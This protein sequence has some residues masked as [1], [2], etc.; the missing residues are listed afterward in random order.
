MQ[1]LK[2]CPFCGHPRSRLM[3]KRE[4]CKDGSDNAAI[5]FAFWRKCNKCG[6][7]SGIVR[8][9]PVHYVY[10]D[11]ESEWAKPWREQADDAWNRRGVCERVM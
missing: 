6:A 10:Y 3:S 1:D 7:T 8:T 11:A 2:P 9:D 5:R 4:H